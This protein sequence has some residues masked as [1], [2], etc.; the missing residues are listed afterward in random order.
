MPI[1]NSGNLVLDKK[2]AFI[3]ALN[4]IV[5][6]TKLFL[7]WFDWQQLE[8]AHL[9]LLSLVQSIPLLISYPAVII[10]LLLTMSILSMSLP[11]NP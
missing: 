1:N 7:M 3:M 8:L 5:L 10:L 2:N 4:T 9:P 11:Q 6:N